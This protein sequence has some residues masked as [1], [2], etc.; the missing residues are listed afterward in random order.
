MKMLVGITESDSFD[1]K[2][3]NIICQ[4]CEIDDY[5]S[6]LYCGLLSKENAIRFLTSL[7][8]SSIFYEK[9]FQKIS[10]SN[11]NQSDLSALKNWSVTMR[12]DEKIL[13]QVLEN[14]SHGDKYINI[15]KIF[16]NSKPLNKL[17]NIHSTIKTR[18]RKIAFITITIL[19]IVIGILHLGRFNNEN[20]LFK[21][22][23]FQ[24]NVQLLYDK[25]GLRDIDVRI[26]NP[27]EIAFVQNYKMSMTDFINGK[28]DKANIGFKKGQPAAINM[29][30]NQLMIDIVRD[31][32]FYWGIS[33]LVSTKAKLPIKPENR[34]ILC[35]ALRLMN[36]AISLAKKNNLADIDRETYYIGLTL[37][38]VG[39]KV[40]A[41]EYL[42]KISSK[43]K[44]HNNSLAL[45]SLWKV[46]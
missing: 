39:R 7:A 27:N 31:Y 36:T 38:L 2:N 12:T 19:I 13:K 15:K 11:I 41:C 40:E 26:N 16:S 9:V 30:Q 34:D 21:L 37:G 23:S 45:I 32:Y 46:N 28:Y 20:R 5:L 33:M 4:G 1:I 6:D 25:S 3:N 43:S 8:A 17:N 14:S 44:Y 10:G 29:L 24:R 42:I 22:I 35:E 18:Y